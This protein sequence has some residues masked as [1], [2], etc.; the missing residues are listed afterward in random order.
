M[1]EGRPTRSLPIAPRP[2]PA[3]RHLPLADARAR[4][5]PALATD[6][7]GLGADAPVRPGLRGTAARARDGRARTSSTPPAC[8]DLVAQMAALGVLEVTVIGGEA[9]LRDDW[10]TIVRA[11]RDAGMQC[12]M[13][14][15]GRG[16]TAEMARAAAAAG[17]Q[18]A[19]VSIDGNEATHDRLRG[20]TGAYR[21]ALAAT[22]HIRAAGMGLSV[23]TQINRLSMRELPDVLETIIA[24][25]ARAWQIQ[26]TVA[27]GRAA[28]E[29]DLLLQPEEMLE[30][31]PL[32]AT[33]KR[34]CDEAGVALWPGNN[35]GY[36]GPF[37][38]VLRGG[39]ARGHMSSC[40]AGCTTLGIEAER[41]HQ[42]LP[43]AAHRPLD[44]RQHPRRQPARHLGALGAAALH[45]RPHRRRSVGLLPHLLLRRRLP[46]RLH[47]DRLQPVRQAGQQPALSPPRAGDAQAGKA[48][49]PGSRRS[50][51]RARRSITGSSKSSSRR[52]RHEP[53][54]ALPR[55]QPPR[56]RR[57]DR[58]PVLR[59]RARRVVP[60]AAAAGAA[61]P[62]P[63]ARG[64]DGR[65]RHADGRRRLQQQRRHHRR[66][67]RGD[68]SSP[69]LLR[70]ARRAVPVV[71]RAFHGDRRNLRRGRNH[72]NRRGR[73]TGGTDA[74]ND[75][76]TDA[77]PARD[78]AQE[79][80]IIAI[81]GAAFAGGLTSDKPQS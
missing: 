57:R 42:G 23:N 59:R 28:D 21:S 15:G 56:R 61:A 43:V 3:L 29:P 50:P 7:R 19:S 77:A 20:V 26:L 2:G 80:S 10:L 35:I 60:R 81:Y 73:S 71:R 25:G 68:R 78:A 5:R 66:Q 41:R 52:S 32:L 13:T 39:I 74:G 6:L 48:R 72:R 46:R 51:A 53:P 37:E 69:G 62:P 12:S 63:L 65:R 22:G 33:L 4:G 38:S 54:R 45:A 47:L 34:R 17:L 58:L 24:L 31:H 70:R 36:F 16:L 1:I 55:V 44:R 27:M 30:L 18:S 79:R 9:Y 40:G 14:T 76:A 49:A 11:V 67:G 75:G 8:L 64:A